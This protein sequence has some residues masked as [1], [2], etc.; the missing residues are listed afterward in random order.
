[1]RSGFPDSGGAV[2][3]PGYA[4]PL[5]LFERGG[6]GWFSH[7]GDDVAASEREP[8]DGGAYDRYEQIVDDIWEYYGG[9]EAAHSREE[10]M[11]ELCGHSPEALAYHAA[12]ET[13][14]WLAWHEILSSRPY[15]PTY[16]PSREEVKARAGTLSKATRR[17]LLSFPLPVQIASIR[18]EKMHGTWR[19]PRLGTLPRRRLL[20]SGTASALCHEEFAY[21][22][23]GL[24]M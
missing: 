5:V 16:L 2:C 8:P 15:P 17:D 1:M 23:G 9:S 19:E 3:D 18:Y 7:S 10:S 6:D 14:E 22:S 4:G 11:W 24:G 13:Q 20:C 12:N 21:S